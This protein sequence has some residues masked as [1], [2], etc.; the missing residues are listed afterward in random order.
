LE[1]PNTSSIENEA[2]FGD[3]ER[4]KP[5]GPYAATIVPDVTI[6]IKIANMRLMNKSQ[7]AKRHNKIGKVMTL[8][9][10]SEWVARIA[11]NMLLNYDAI[12]GRKAKTA[13]L[14]CT[15]YSICDDFLLVQSRRNSTGHSNRLR[16]HYEQVGT[17]FVVGVY[18]KY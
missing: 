5:R 3:S 15:R 14:I 9:H 11:R 4:Q 17:T 10:L 2:T 1:I 12:P 8:T 18:Y 13:V 16:Q 6:K 7:H